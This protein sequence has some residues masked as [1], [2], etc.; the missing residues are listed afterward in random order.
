MFLE[1]QYRLV[2]QSVSS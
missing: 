1:V 2:C